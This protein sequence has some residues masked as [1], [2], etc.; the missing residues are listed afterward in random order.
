MCIRD[1]SIGL[2][3]TV[4]KSEVAEKPEQIVVDLEEKPESEIPVL[5]QAETKKATATNDSLLSRLSISLGLIFCFAIGLFLFLKWWSKNHKVHDMQGKIRVLTQHHI[6]PKKTLAIIR[7]AGESILVGIT[8]HSINHIKTLSLLDGEIPDTVPGNFKNE[9]DANF[10]E[11]E[12]AAQEVV[13]SF[14][15][16]ENIKKTITSRLKGIGR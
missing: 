10:Q 11:E 7:V 12:T 5:T 2:S 8:D 4:A 16:G 3:E 15:Y 13:D 6:G 14:S 1:S 9:L